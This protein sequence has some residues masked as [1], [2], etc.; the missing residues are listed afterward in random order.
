MHQFRPTFL[1]S[2]YIL[3]VLNSAA[4]YRAICTIEMGQPML[5]GLGITS[6]IHDHII[7]PKLIAHN[8]IATLKIR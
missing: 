7:C 8:L 6:C 3:K 1:C 2:A 5:I 4:I